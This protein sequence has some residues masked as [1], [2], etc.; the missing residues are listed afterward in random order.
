MAKNSMNMTMEVE[1]LDQCL[2]KIKLYDSTTQKQIEKAISKAGR[3]VRD[4]AKLRVPVKTG[5]LR[6]NIKSSFSSAKLQSVVKVEYKKAP[7][8]HL[9]EFGTD[10]YTVRPKNKKALKFAWGNY[11]FRA[12]AEIPVRRARPYL[13]PAFK[14]E[15]PKLSKKFIEILRTMP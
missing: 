2:K 5:K 10:S 11:I 14:A 7:H 6:D 13:K 4:D 1:G 15:E 9:I 3:T 8:A 12:K